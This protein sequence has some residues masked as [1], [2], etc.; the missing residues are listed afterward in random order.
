MSDFTDIHE[1][2]TMPHPFGGEVYLELKD[3]QGSPV[4]LTFNDLWVLIVCRTS[5]D[6]DWG[7]AR[8]AAGMVPDPARKRALVERLWKLEQILDGLPTVPAPVLRLH[9][10][11][12]HLWF[13]Q[14]PVSDARNW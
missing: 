4:I 7:R 12:A 1:H 8:E 3:P 13:N 6:G 10:H 2:K 14:R 9:M 5:H 11:R